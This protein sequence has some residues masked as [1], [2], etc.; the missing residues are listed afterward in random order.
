MAKETIEGTFRKMKVGQ[1]RDFP[2]ASYTGV[3]SEAVRQNKEARL[4]K[5]IAEHEIAFRVSSLKKNEGLC[6]V[7]RIK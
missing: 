7:I 6:S 4:L 3:R 1:K 2:F 5:K